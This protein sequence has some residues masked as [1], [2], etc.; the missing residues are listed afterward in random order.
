MNTSADPSRYPKDTR[1]RTHSI[2]YAIRKEEHRLRMRHSWLQYQSQMGLGFL[3]A[4]LAAM[5]LIASLYLRGHLAW[6]LTVPLMALPLSIVYEIEHD[7]LHHLYFR[8]HLWFQNLLLGVTW[9]CKLGMNPWTRREFH[10]H[11]HKVSGQ[12]E[13][14]EE[15]IMGLGTRSLLLRL[16]LTASP[17]SSTLLLL[18]IRRDVP[19]FQPRKILVGLLPSLLIADLLLVL[20]L[21]YTVPSGLSPDTGSGW[22]PVWGW[23]WVRGALTLWVLPNAL[24]QGCLAL[25]SSY[26]HY[27]EDIPQGDVFFQNQILHHPLVW[28]LNLFAFNFGKTHIIHHFV[29][30]QPFY[31]RQM[32]SSVALEELKKQGARINDF[33]VISRANRWGNPRYS[34]LNS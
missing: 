25:I 29:A 28:P 16:V 34:I 9:L 5:A 8:N 13:D 14:I 1:A 31:L 2:N 27:Y 17:L 26:S 3:L 30:N 33:A 4:S 32:V 18:D 15:R 22:L 6:W 24:R 7:L 20:A 11:H 10:L 21:L 23:P 12:R 19:G